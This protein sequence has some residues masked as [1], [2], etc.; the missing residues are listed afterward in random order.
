M[1]NTQY[2]PVESMV[3]ELTLFFFGRLEVAAIRAHL[4][5][6]LRSGATAFDAIA[7]CLWK[8]RTAALARAADEA[9]AVMRMIC[10]VSA[11]RNSKPAPGAATIP[12]GYYGNTFALPAALATAGELAANPVGFA[13]QQAKRGVDLE[14]VRSVSDLMALRGRPHFTVARAFLL[15]DV[16][17][18]GF[19][20]VDFGW[21]KPAYGG[22]AKGSVGPVPGMASFLIATNKR[23]PMARTASWCPCASPDL[24]WTGSRRRWT[25][26]C[27]R[28]PAGPRS[29]LG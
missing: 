8:C 2:V 22:P 25:R 18:A 29:E 12:E 13:V 28:Q 17:K 14:Y 5:P 21:G 24:P 15:S 26:C 27:A 6:P 10:I 20:D 9:R 11:R 19:G 3:F 23:V 1:S 4:P 7:G 16:T